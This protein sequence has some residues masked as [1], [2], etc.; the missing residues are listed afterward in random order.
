MKATINSIDAALSDLKLD[1]SRSFKAIYNDKY[2][3]S[4][5]EFLVFMHIW[6]LSQLRNEIDTVKEWV[7]MKFM[8]K[9]PPK[10]I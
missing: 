1:L 5:R 2:G 8:S 9:S 10:S 7:N 3:L 6:P 4:S